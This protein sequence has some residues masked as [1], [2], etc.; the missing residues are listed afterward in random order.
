MVNEKQDKPNW[1][2]AELLKDQ[3]H[4][5]AWTSWMD[6]IFLLQRVAP[7]ILSTLEP[8]YVAQKCALSQLLEP[9]ASNPWPTKPGRP[10]V[11]KGGGGGGPVSQDVPELLT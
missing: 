6:L 9:P 7:D 2:K 4:N 10:L 1:G 11:P 3:A 5:L 8:P